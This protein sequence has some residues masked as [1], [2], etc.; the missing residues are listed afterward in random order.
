MPARLRDAARTAVRRIV[1]VPGVLSWRAA[2][3]P[4]RVAIEVRGAAEL[5]F[6]TWAADA[7]TVAE[8]LR[9]NGLRRGDR[10]GLPFGGRDWAGFAVAYCGV[11]RAGG[12]AVPYSDRLPAT[13][14]RRLLEDCGAVGIV[15]P[16]AASPT[17]PERGWAVSVAELAASGPA[18]DDRAD[19]DAE[20]DDLAQIL[21]TSGTTGRPKGVG[22]TH[23]NLTL[24]VTTDPRRMPL[25][26]SERFLHAFAIG[27]NAAQTMLLNAL[28]ARPAMVTVPQ[29]TPVRFARLIGSGE[30]GSLFLVPS[31][32]IE[33]LNSGALEG[34]DTGRVQLV[35]S[36]A[37]A[38]PPAVAVA[39]ARRFPAATIVNYYTSTEAAPAQ[40]SMIFDPG[41]PEA[42]GRP[43]SGTLKIA[44]P[45]GEPLPAGAVGAVWLRTPYSRSYIGDEA[46][47]RET[48]RDGWVRMGDVGRL[49]ADGYLFL[50]DRESDVVKSGAYK[51]STLE[52]EA[53]LYEHPD[54]AEAAVIG[55]PHPVLGRSLAAAVV[56][57]GSARPQ[58]PVLREFLAERL[59]DHQLPSRLL[60]LDALPRNDAGKVL[61]R[62]LVTRFSGADDGEEV[63]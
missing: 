62:H 50:V 21:Y 56:P 35:G 2:L 44:D 49:D 33:L 31:T 58:L 8:A 22:A 10:V 48:F 59:A 12:V 60:L 16:A 11:Q 53:A 41:R 5:T 52:I 23:H 13:P 39:L 63:A 34:R 43:V 6:G 24:G 29:F 9:R 54:V 14:A 17:V 20:P 7:A 46:S 61:K 30:I 19:G 47:S 37:A 36:T 15:H 3:Q 1:T 26:H 42:L 40:T 18:G 32:A 4:Q 38:L 28:V 27:T 55:L 25:A 51:I 57:R 45:D